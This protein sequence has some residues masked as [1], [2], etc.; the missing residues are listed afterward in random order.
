MN[1]F[2]EYAEG[3]SVFH[4]LNPLT[5]L[6]LALLLCISS[7]LSS[8]L[9]FLLGLIGLNL[10]IAFSAG[11]GRRALKMLLGLINLS[12]LIF[13]LQVLFIRVG[14]PYPLPFGIRI[15]DTGLSIGALVVLRLIG[16][17]MPLALMLSLTKISD[18]SRTL[19]DRLR[20][21]YRYVFAL[22]TALR[23]VPL[24]SQEM[25]RIM[26]V[27]TSRGVAFD[28]RNILKKIRLILPLCIP[29][30]VSSVQKIETEAISAELR[31]FHLREQL[32]PRPAA[33]LHS[34]DFCMSALS[35]A[36]L[37]ASILL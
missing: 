16:A 1:G 22:T 29:L 20:I 23:F 3:N 27:Q 11:I 9:F 6:I 13:L 14:T 37:A 35:V 8:N 32:P 36:V 2:L 18:L 7:F 21:P 30:L 28:T 5:K 31:G 25:Q 4:K 34:C 17:T 12:V 33:P 24:F 15:T 10:I 26:E 19:T